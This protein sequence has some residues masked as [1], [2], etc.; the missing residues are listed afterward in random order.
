MKRQTSSSTRC[1]CEAVLLDGPLAGAHVQVEMLPD[2]DPIGVLSIRD[3]RRGC[4]V[5]AGFTGPDGVLPYR[6]VAWEGRVAL[7]GWLRFCRDAR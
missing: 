7:R 2:G 1:S 3:D 6:W 5:C 4:Y